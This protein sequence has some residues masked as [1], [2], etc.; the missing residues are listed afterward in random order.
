MNYKT[1]RI[2]SIDGAVT[3]SPNKDRNTWTRIRG[4]FLSRRRNEK[5]INTLRWHEDRKDAGSWDAE[6][7]ERVSRSPTS[8]IRKGSRWRIGEFWGSGERREGR[9]KKRGCLLIRNGRASLRCFP[10]GSDRLPIWPRVGYQT[11]ILLSVHPFIPT[12][13]VPSAPRTIIC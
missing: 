9:R 10:C 3:H 13:L 6:T 2:K 4:T 8:S 11:P 12:F 5:E 7:E 1:Q